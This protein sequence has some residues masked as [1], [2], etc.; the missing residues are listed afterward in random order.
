MSKLRLTVP[1]LRHR[2]Q[3]AT[4]FFHLLLLFFTFLFL[5]QPT[6]AQLYHKSMYYNS[7]CVNPHSYMFRH[8]FMS[9]SDSVQ[10]MPC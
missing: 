9:S 8:F 2:G 4:P 3:T 1:F 5:L 7:L 10:P 6:N